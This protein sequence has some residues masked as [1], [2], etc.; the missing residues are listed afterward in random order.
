MT[1]YSFCSEHFST[2]MFFFLSFFFKDYFFKYI[3]HT[4][5]GNDFAFFARNMV[6]VSGKQH[7]VLCMLDIR[8]E[9]WTIA[10]KEKLVVLH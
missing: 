2:C 3:F 6:A 8:R 5:N 10:V 9:S 4:R 7:F 1:K